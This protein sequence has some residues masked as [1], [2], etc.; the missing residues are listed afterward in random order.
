M[1][2][3]TYKFQKDNGEVVEV[4]FELMMTQLGGIIE[5]PDGSTARRIYDQEEVERA[6]MRRNCQTRVESDALGFPV[7]QLKEMQA[8][9]EIN[10]FSGIDFIRD[11]KS[12]TH[13]R[14]RATDH[15]TLARYT[16]AR[17]W[18][19]KSSKNGSGALLAG[20]D[21]DRLSNIIKR[22]HG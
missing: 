18:V 2:E 10:G 1:S 4:G 20:V 13:Y 6:E 9:R 3:E 5:L 22:V 16:A 17:G 8:H 7:H 19:N 11:D 15:A 21:M 12:D 14:V